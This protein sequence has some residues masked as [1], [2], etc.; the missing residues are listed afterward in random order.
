MVL[1]LQKLIHLHS[2]SDCESEN[3]DCDGQVHETKRAAKRRKNKKRSL[4]SKIT[5][6][7]R[8]SKSSKEPPESQDTTAD[9]NGYIDADKWSSVEAPPPR[10]SACE[11]H[12]SAYSACWGLIMTKA[13]SSC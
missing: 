10:V 9:L 3:S 8:S 6:P 2:E 12:Y 13:L 7:F 11:V 1:P 5:K 4:L